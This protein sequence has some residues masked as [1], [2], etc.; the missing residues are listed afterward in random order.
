MRRD[1]SGRPRRGA[2]AVGRAEGTTMVLR[3]AFERLAPA[4][5]DALRAMARVRT[6][7]PDTVLCREGEVDHTIYVVREGLVGIT[8]RGPAGEERLLMVRGAGE[9]FGELS[10]LDDAPRLATVR[11]VGDVS[12]IEITKAAFSAL[13]HDSPTLALTLLRQAQADR[14]SL[15]QTQIQELQDANRELE[16]SNLRLE[17]AQAQLVAAERTRRDLEIAAQIQRSILPSSLPS[18][19][20]WSF[21]GRALPA[22]EMGGDFYDVYPLDGGRAGLLIADV[23][24]K[25]VP[26]A[27]FMGV[28]RTLF[29]TEARRSASPLAVC[30][31]V[32][33]LLLEAASQ[34]LF[35]TAFYGVANLAARTLTYVRAGHDLPLLQHADGS[36]EPLLGD[37]RF[38]GML[39]D[40]RAEE[41][42]VSLRPGDRLLLFTD[43]V[44]DA[45]DPRG[46]RFT[47]ERLEDLAR[48]SRHEG[49]ETL[50]ALIVDQVEGF[51]AGSPPFDD[52]TLLVAA[53]D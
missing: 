43:G 10:L 13:M 5:L 53:L 27:L 12:V 48:Q 29:L 6:Y 45:T 9:L 51:R 24:D 28:A 20:G 35:V 47:R 39:P 11:T 46:Q 31:A 50:A 34:D 52:V 44:T 37:G 17:Q 25:G 26:A 23:S 4:D 16:L 22:R 36:A 2:S 42:T 14:R 8:K 15:L 3:A 32:N 1:P 33:D 19:P 49:A 18:F 21:A 38:L 7:P 40:L 41:R 30:R